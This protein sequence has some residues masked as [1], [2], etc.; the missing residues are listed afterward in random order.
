MQII[1]ICLFSLPLSLFRSV[2]VCVIYSLDST[3]SAK[4]L[5]LLTTRPFDSAMAAHLA[6]SFWK[7]KEIYLCQNLIGFI[8]SCLCSFF[9]Q[10][11]TN[12][13]KKNTMNKRVCIDENTQ[14]AKIFILSQKK[15]SVKQVKSLRP[16]L[17]S[18][19]IMYRHFL[20]TENCNKVIFLRL[21]C[22]LFAHWRDD[23]NGDGDDGDNNAIFC[24]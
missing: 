2:C 8:I 17:N 13:R 5:F 1:F 22:L 7:H 12:D 10:N 18:T 16:H 14:W 21:I 4:M 24:A 23:G 3:S 11:E 6:S 20:F 19:V 15:R 9:I